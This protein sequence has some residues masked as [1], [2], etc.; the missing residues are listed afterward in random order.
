[1]NNIRYCK[2]CGNRLSTS[3]KFCQVCKAA[4]VIP[5]PA[6]AGKKTIKKKSKLTIL[7][8]VLFTALCIA[9]LMTFAVFFLS[10]I[11]SSTA[12]AK[13]NAGKSNVKNSDK[14]TINKESADEADIENQYY[15]KSTTKIIYFK[16]NSMMV[17]SLKNTGDKHVLS[18]NYSAVNEMAVDSLSQLRWLSNDESFLYSMEDYKKLS[19]DTCTYTLYKTASSAADGQQ[20][21]N[22]NALRRF[23]LYKAEASAPDE[24]SPVKIADNVQRH[25]LLTGNKLLFWSDNKIYYY[26]GNSAAAVTSGNTVAGQLSDDDKSIIYAEDKGDGKADLYYKSLDN[27]SNMSLPLITDIV[28]INEDGNFFYTDALLNNIYVKKDNGIYKVDSKGTVTKLLSDVEFVLSIATD[29]KNNQVYFTRKGSE[30]SLYQLCYFNNN[31][32]TILSENFIPKLIQYS[33]VREGDSDAYSYSH[34][35]INKD[36]DYII[37]PE[38]SDNAYKLKIAVEGKNIFDVPVPTDETDLNSDD[39]TSKLIYTAREAGSDKAYFF[40]KGRESTL[41]YALSLNS[42]AEKYEITKISENISNNTT[43]MKAAKDGIY[44]IND[45]ALYYN[46]DKMVEYDELKLETEPCKKDNVILYYF[47]GNNL[48]ITYEDTYQE[49]PEAVNVKDVW[50]RPDGSAVFLRNY[51]EN[52]KSGELAYFDGKSTVI[53]DSGVNLFG[54]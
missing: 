31:E 25:A 32:V 18:N 35:A 36:F 3:D 26:D 8:M 54:H 30:E 39:N 20:Q 50:F 22:R 2:H 51:D 4:R 33:K 48:G 5:V 46:E 53:I 1:M 47:N 38:Y 11:N 42:T 16:D 52:L 34:T 13:N 21:A 9:V 27:L 44:Y 14:K 45:K 23:Q 24:P 28:K 29:T 12:N 19:D 49:I 37:Y 10:K 17:A 7:I 40:I 41:L 43:Q 15:F 6:Q